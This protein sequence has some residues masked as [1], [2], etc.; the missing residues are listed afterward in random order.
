M[1]VENFGEKVRF[2]RTQRG[3]GQAELARRMKTS[4]PTISRIENGGR[5]VS[6]QELVTLAAV[7]Q[8]S[9]STFVEHPVPFDLSSDESETLVGIMRVFRRLPRPVLRRVLA[10]AEESEQY[11]MPAPPP[12]VE[13]LDIP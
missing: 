1:S 5:D 2:Y 7:F 6:R 11:F 13:T 4:V 9:L 3:W 8:L 10:L 12:S